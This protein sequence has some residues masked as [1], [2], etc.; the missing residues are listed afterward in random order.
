MLLMRWDKHLKP[1]NLMLQLNTKHQRFVVPG[2]VTFVA[3]S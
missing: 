3:L 2:G 1:V